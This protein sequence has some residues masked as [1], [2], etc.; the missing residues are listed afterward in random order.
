M[1]RHAA[2]SL[3][4]VVNPHLFGVIIS[5]LEDSLNATAAAIAKSIKQPQ[6]S[7]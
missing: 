5:K 7:H 1:G 2:V 3:V 6:L 4:E